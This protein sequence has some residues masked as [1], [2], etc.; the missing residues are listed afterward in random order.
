MLREVWGVVMG[1]MITDFVGIVN[2]EAKVSIF[3]LQTC[4]SKKKFDKTQKMWYYITCV[5]F[6]EIEECPLKKL[7]VVF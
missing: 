5:Y 6:R 3:G 2:K 4:D 1:I 7:R